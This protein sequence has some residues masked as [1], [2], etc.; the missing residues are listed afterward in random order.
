[1]GLVMLPVFMLVWVLKILEVKSNNYGCNNDFKLHVQVG[2]IVQA[3]FLFIYFFS[4]SSF[5]NAD[6]LH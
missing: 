5:K 4:F 6:S 3:T 1:M 2:S